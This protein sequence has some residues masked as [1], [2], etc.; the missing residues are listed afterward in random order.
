MS[1]D[2]CKFNVGVCCCGGTVNCRDLLNFERRHADLGAFRKI[3]DYV[4]KGVKAKIL[5]GDAVGFEDICSRNLAEV[6]LDETP[7][8]LPHNCISHSDRLKGICLGKCYAPNSSS[9]IDTVRFLG[10]AELTLVSSNDCFRW[11]IQPAMDSPAVRR[12]SMVASTPAPMI[13]TTPTQAC[14]GRF[15]S[16]SSMPKTL[17]KITVL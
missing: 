16:H 2:N 9:A 7:W 4:S 14:Q 3:V 17:E 10:E 15:S 6:S 11:R 5:F 12:E 8:L 1:C 13:R